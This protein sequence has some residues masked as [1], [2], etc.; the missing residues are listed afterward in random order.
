MGVQIDHGEVVYHV[1]AS[2]VEEVLR[3]MAVLV[4]AVG[5]LVASR[6]GVYHHE[7]TRVPVA[8]DVLDLEDQ[9]SET[10]VVRLGMVGGDTPPHNEAFLEVGA[11]HV[12]RTVVLDDPEETLDLEKGVC[13]LAVAEETVD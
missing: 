5:G 11:P 8:E 2:R 1:T 4:D 10:V 7:C 3:E 12:L 6:E 9:L 13:R